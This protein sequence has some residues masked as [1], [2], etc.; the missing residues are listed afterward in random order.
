MIDTQEKDVI[1]LLNTGEDLG[2]FND[3]LILTFSV[4][5]LSNST[6]EAIEKIEGY[7]LSI[8]PIK[9]EYKQMNKIL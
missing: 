1:Y 3:A 6:V 8:K 7:N 2:S 5:V 9:K 4:I